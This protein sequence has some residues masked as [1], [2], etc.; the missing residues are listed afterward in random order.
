ML[1]IQF[2]PIESGT[3]SLEFV[4]GGAVTF[5]NLNV[6]SWSANVEMILSSFQLQD[7]LEFIIYDDYQELTERLLAKA[8]E[9]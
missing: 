5:L 7:I 2:K 8:Q 3:G 1:F 6:R 4:T 9:E